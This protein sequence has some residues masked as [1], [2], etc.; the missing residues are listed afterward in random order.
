MN[1]LKAKLNIDETFNKRKRHK[2]DVVKDN[3]YREK[4]YNYMADLLHL[5]ETKEGYKYLII[6]VDLWSDSFDMEPMKDKTADEALKAMKKIFTRKYVKKPKASIRTDNGKEFHG[7]FHNWLNEHDVLQRYALPYRHKQLS[8]VE[9]LNRTVGRLLNGYMNSFERKTK[10]DYR[11]W[12]NELD[13]IRKGLNEIRE[14]RRK[15]ALKNYDPDDVENYIFEMKNP[16]FNV[17]DIVYHVSEIPYSATGKRQNTKNFRVGDV[18]YDV[19][20]PK[21]ITKV[22][23]YSKQIRY[24]LKGLKNVSYAESELLLKK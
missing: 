18:T 21:E 6:I 5:P 10:K 22:L 1:A 8:N 14:K 12:T 11:E 17:G 19:D 9:N 20:N 2:F 16:K 13:T 15:K 4:G 24:M 23:Y 3:V 7:V